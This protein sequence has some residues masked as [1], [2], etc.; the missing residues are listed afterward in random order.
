MCRT[1]PDT[2]LKLCMPKRG[3]GSASLLVAELQGPTGR[4]LGSGGNNDNFWARPHV[5]WIQDSA[6]AL[7][8]PAIQSMGPD[9]Q[10]GVCSG[11]AGH[12]GQVPGEGRQQT[13]HRSSAA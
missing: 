3:P 13:P 7:C 12:R 5:K 6:K 10:S 8:M 9:M 1:C 2:A 4:N 11:H